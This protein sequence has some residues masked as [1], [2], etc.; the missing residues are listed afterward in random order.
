MLRGVEEPP[1]SD[2]IHDTNFT[3]IY[4]IDALLLGL[5][6]EYSTNRWLN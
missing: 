2:W 4:F 5:E 1:G 6:V 3:D